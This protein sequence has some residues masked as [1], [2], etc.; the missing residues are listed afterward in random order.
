MK[1]GGPTTINDVHDT[2][3]VAIKMLSESADRIEWLVETKAS[4]SL[5]HKEIHVQHRTIAT[6]DLLV[7]LMEDIYARQGHKKTPQ[8][9][10]KHLRR[11]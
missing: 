10:R 3:R 5:L 4:A 8:E 11:P 9:S 1:S 2:T 6:L 7:G